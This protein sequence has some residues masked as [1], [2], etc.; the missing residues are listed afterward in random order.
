MNHSTD[1]GSLC[2]FL[3][4]KKNKKTSSLENMRLEPKREEVIGNSSFQKETFE[5]VLELLPSCFSV[6]GWGRGLHPRFSFS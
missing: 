2:L 3:M 5:I 4:V 6:R 1:V